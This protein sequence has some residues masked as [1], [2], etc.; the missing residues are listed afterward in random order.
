MFFCDFVNN[1]LMREIATS[2]HNTIERIKCLEGIPL[3]VKVIGP[4]GKSSLIYGVVTDIFPAVFTVVTDS[5]E[6]KTFSY[7]DVHAG[8]ILFLKR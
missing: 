2:I 5:G 3:V 1:L 4:R 8:N 6:K 7:S